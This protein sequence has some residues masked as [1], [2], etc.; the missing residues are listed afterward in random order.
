MYIN[1]LPFD[2][3]FLK[4]TVWSF[5]NK[6]QVCVEEFAIKEKDIFLKIHCTVLQLSNSIQKEF[7]SGT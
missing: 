5:L 7:F 2:Y 1:F 4:G 6:M 3:E